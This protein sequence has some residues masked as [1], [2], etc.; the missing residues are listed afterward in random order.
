M[1][2]VISLLL[3]AVLVLVATALGPDASSATETCDSAPLPGAPTVKVLVMGDSLT[4]ASAGDYT[5]RYRL[6]EAERAKGVNID[7]VG[8]FTGLGGTWDSPTANNQL[9]ADPCFTER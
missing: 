9:Y 7:F 4:S 1:A 3:G 6:W 5:W 8:P 2:C